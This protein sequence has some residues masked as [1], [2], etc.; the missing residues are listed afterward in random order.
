M[1]KGLHN[2]YTKRWGCIQAWKETIET[3]LLLRCNS[4]KKK[5]DFI[6]EEIQKKPFILLELQSKYYLR[7]G[8]DK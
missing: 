1:T 2:T 5:I 4:H 6:K 7:Y 3:L 8:K